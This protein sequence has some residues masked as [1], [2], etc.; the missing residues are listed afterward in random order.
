MVADDNNEEVKLRHIAE[1][2]IKER[3]DT[4]RTVTLETRRASIPDKQ[5]EGT[6]GGALHLSFSI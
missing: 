1:E 5:S 2:E 3:N 4:F 6:D